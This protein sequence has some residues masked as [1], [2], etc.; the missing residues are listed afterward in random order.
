MKCFKHLGLIALSLAGL[1]GAQ[2]GT[3]F[4]DNFNSENGGVGT[5]NYTGFANWNVASGGGAVDLIGNGFFDFLPG[6]GLYVDTEGSTGL[7]GTMVTKST[8]NFVPGLDYTLSFDLAGDQRGGDRSEIVT[9]GGGSILDKDLV[10][11]SG[12]GFT[13]ETFSFTVSSDESSTLSF[14]AGENGDVGLLLDNVELTSASPNGVPDSGNTAILLAGGGAALALMSG[15][16]RNQ[17][18]TVRVQ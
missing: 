5:L 16:S 2:A 6:N 9:V 13:L 3:L 8:F 17:R 18:Q 15:L 7:G 14:A 1:Q 10:L 12:Q 11:P 4:S